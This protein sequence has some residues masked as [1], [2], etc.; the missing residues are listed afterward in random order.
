MR[1]V[2]ELTVRFLEMDV[3]LLQPETDRTLNC[4]TLT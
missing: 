3:T 1:H 4:S 2:G